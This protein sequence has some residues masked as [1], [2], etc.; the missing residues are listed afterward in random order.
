M[1]RKPVVMAG[2]Y[3]KTQREKDIEAGIIL[4]YY[5]LSDINSLPEISQNDARFAEKVCNEYNKLPYDDVCWLIRDL[6]HGVEKYQAD[7]KA[8]MLSMNSNF[9]GKLCTNGIE[10]KSISINSNMGTIELLAN[11]II[12]EHYF[13]P[14]LKKIKLLQRDVAESFSKGQKYSMVDLP[15]NKIWQFLSTTKLGPSQ[16]K[17]VAGMFLVYF[18]LYKGKPLMTE[19]EFNANSTYPGTYKRYLSDRVKDWLSA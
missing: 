14:Q 8:G 13:Y 16:R 17:V 4:K 15:F 9:W 5:F 7:Y 10:F 2:L 19:I 3:E 18:N 1:K 11:H 6:R 12:F